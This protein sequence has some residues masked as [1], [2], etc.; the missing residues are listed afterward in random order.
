MHIKL[1]IGE[2]VVY[3]S[4][5]TSESTKRESRHS[6]APAGE[7][8]SRFYSSKVPPPVPCSRG[9]VGQLQCPLSRETNPDTNRLRRLHSRLGM[10]PL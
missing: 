1:G 8:H 10:D 4:T 6:N 9:T 2:E 5:G 7:N 3:A